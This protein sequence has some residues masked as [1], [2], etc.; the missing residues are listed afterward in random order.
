MT[1]Q[2]VPGVW[3]A[4]HE[5]GSYSDYSYE[6][7]GVYA[8]RK[9]AKQKLIAWAEKNASESEADQRK[10]YPSG[11]YPNGVLIDFSH[12]CHQY[13]LDDYRW[14]DSKGKSE[15]RPEKPPTRLVDAKGRIHENISGIDFRNDWLRAEC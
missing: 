1:D 9:L 3:L 13:G 6:V 8:T 10:R 7:L 12:Y 14:F 2:V 11:L 5:S 15:W 4:I